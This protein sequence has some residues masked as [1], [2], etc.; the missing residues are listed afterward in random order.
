MKHKD[1]APYDEYVRAH[2]LRWPVVQQPDGTWRET[3]FRFAEFDDPYVKKGAGIE[4]YHSPSEDGRAQ[5][6][7][8]P[9]EEPP[10][11]PDAEYPFW[12]CT[13][14]VLEHWH[15]GTMTGRI[16][17]LRR[18][19]PQAYVE[20]HRDDAQRLGITNGDTVRI[21]SRR[22]HLDLP[23]WIDGRGAP[24]E[25]SVFVPFF[26]ERLLVNF[27]T[28]EAHDPFSKQPDFKKCAVRV[29]RLPG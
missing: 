19:M 9:Y 7:F 26:D 17:Q 22:G 1:L 12:L 27:V 23:A 13:G 2:G 6:W 11:K 15:T 20:I 28:L 5:I 21:E 24:P 10:E 25:G 16:P 8:H 4:F 14:R 29:A 18:A 3:R